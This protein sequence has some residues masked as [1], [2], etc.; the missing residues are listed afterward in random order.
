MRRAVTGALARHDRPRS[1]V[2]RGELLAAIEM[3]DP[4]NG[5]LALSPLAG[6][7]GHARRLESGNVALSGC[8]LFGP[9]P[10]TLRAYCQRMR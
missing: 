4:M 1:L 3:S 2:R 9:S 7:L 10:E 8:D 5:A 6:Y